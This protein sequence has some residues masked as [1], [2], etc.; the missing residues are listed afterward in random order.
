MNLTPAETAWLKEAAR[1]AERLGKRKLTAWWLLTGAPGSGKTTQTRLFATH[2]WPVVEDPARAEL[3]SALAQGCDPVAVRNDYLQFQEHVLKRALAS[4]ER[5]DVSM[6][7]IFDYGLAEALAFMKVARVPWRDEFV[8]AAALV[9]FDKVFLLDLVDLDQH[10][11]PDPIRTESIDTRRLLHG[12]VG[13]LYAAL[14]HQTIHVPALPPHERL[15]LM[16]GNDALP[17]TVTP[18]R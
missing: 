12:L 7:V 3:E 5:V 13:E 4:I 17:S 16:L 9:K 10:T 14:G 11:T 1:E 18:S 6:Q 2:G 8:R 15:R